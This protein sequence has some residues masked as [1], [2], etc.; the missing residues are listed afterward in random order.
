MYQVELELLSTIS[1]TIRP[2]QKIGNSEHGEV[3]DNFYSNALLIDF[4]KL[5]L[6]KDVDK[7]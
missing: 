5:Y 4:V 3:I 1:T 6:K 2:L 7:A